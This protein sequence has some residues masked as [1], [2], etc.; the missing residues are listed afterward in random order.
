MTTLQREHK[1]ANSC[2][3]FIQNLSP[4]VKLDFIS[5]ILAS[6]KRDKE[7]K[8]SKEKYFAG[9]WDSEQTAEELIEI[10][11]Q[12]RVTIDKSLDF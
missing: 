6:I 3:I 7:P 9:A 5:N 1:I 8:I 10:I 2:M 11:K 12:G 4:E